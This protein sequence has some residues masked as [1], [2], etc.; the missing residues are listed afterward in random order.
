MSEAQK[1]L[2][3]IIAESM[4]PLIEQMERAMV[5][6]DSGQK[7]MTAQSK[8]IEDMSQ[9]LVDIASFTAKAIKE[10]DDPQVAWSLRMIATSLNTLIE[11]VQQV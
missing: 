5:A 1:T 3:A 11:K 2:E 4:Q 10:C 8:V 7:L 9:A 6:I